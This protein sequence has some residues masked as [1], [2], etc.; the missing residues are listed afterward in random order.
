M[1]WVQGYARQLADVKTLG[2]IGCIREKAT[3]QSQIPTGQ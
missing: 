1:V 3:L 2:C